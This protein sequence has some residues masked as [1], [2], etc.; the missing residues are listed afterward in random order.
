MRER[1][2]RRS[3]HRRAKIDCHTRRL[4]AAALP[5]RHCFHGQM[6]A[7]GGRS[8]GLW[9]SACLLPPSPS[10]FVRLLV[11]NDRVLR[12][13]CLVDLALQLVGNFGASRPSLSRT[14]T[15]TLVKVL[16]AL[17]NWPKDPTNSGGMDFIGWSHSCDTV[18]SHPISGVHRTGV[19]LYARATEMS[20]VTVISALA[21]A[22]SV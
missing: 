14:Q 18:R 20:F 19:S 11:Y 1:A 4:A 8:L 22:Q 2:P 17:A 15:L 10:P 12:A 16:R 13:Q 7:Q 9:A 3:A 6:T 21:G 5:P